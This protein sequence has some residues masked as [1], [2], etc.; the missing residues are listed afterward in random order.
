MK[1]IAML[2][3]V[4]MLVIAGVSAEGV[5][6]TP[7]PASNQPVK[8][9]WSTASVPGDAHTVAMG[10]F[11]SEVERLSA[12]NI[13][14]DNF[15]SGSLFAQGV[16]LDATMQGK[17][18]IVYTSAS[19]TAQYVP[20]AS[21]F[22]AAFTF[23][24]YE[25]MTKTLNGPVGQKVYDQVT[26]KLGVRPLMAFYLGTRQLNLTEKAGPV[27][28]PEQM[29]TIKMR[30]PNAP[31]WIA[32]GRALGANPTPMSFGEV[33]MGLKTG[34]VDAQDNPLPTDKNAKFYEVTKY[35]VLTSHV[36]DSV[37]PSINEK[38]WQ[39]LSAQQKDWVMQAMNTAR[40]FCDKTNLENEKNILSFFKDQGLTIIEN[41]DKAAFAAY[42]KNFYLNEG[43]DISKDWDWKLYEEIQKIK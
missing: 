34:V 6:E 10:V 11:K 18:D 39:S 16:D 40:V 15:D 25:Q 35:I 30:V 43:K 42:A 21:M 19:L 31:A 27:T 20:T 24:S 28:K 29:K 3:L 8:L 32:M 33:Y 12:G 1:R 36:V 37:W 38:R 17:I 9:V 7:A 2:M 41:P 22:G 23:Q 5:K 26:A 13:T 4:V 14:V